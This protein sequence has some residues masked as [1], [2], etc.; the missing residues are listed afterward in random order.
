MTF[1]STW[2]MSKGSASVWESDMESLWAE[3]LT[4][5]AQLQP[6]L[7]ATPSPFP[8]SKILISMRSNFGELITSFDFSWFLI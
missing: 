6:I 5:A 2:T 3:I 7:S 1:S 8:Q 4:E